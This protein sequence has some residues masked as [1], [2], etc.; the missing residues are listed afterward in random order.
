MG[1]AVAGMH[2]A[3]MRGSAFRMQP[4]EVAHGIASLGQSKL[5]IGVAGS[6]FLILFLALIAAMFDR[7]YTETQSRLAKGSAD[8]LRSQI[9]S[10]PPRRSNAGARRRGSNHGRDGGDARS[11]SASGTYRLLPRR[12]GWNARFRPWRM[13]GGRL[14]DARRAPYGR[15][16]RYF[17]CRDGASARE[18]RIVRRTGRRHSRSRD[19]LRN[20]GI[21]R[22]AAHGARQLAWRLLRPSDRPPELDERRDQLG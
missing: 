3:A 13:L 10:A 18:R 1:L 4:G 7:R 5:A 8:R 15:G 9:P 2:Y 21:H 11:L 16:L 17:S 22:R 12:T 14:G 6:T 19:C 20:C